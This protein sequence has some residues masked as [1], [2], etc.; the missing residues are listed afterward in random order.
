M[1][2]FYEVFSNIKWNPLDFKLSWSHYREL[3]IV[4]NIDRIIYCYDIISIRIHF[5]SLF[6]YNDRL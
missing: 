3:L 1:R 2:Q 4:K 6:L 5:D